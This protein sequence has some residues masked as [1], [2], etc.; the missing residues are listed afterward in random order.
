MQKKKTKTAATAGH[1]ES[2]TAARTTEEAAATAARLKSLT[3]NYS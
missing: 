2:G 1:S 3:P